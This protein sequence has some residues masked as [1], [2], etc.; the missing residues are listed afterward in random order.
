MS[1]TVQLLV[2]TAAALLLAAL[3]MAP[4]VP[5]DTDDAELGVIKAG[6]LPLESKSVSAV[7][8]A[9]TKH[10]TSEAMHRTLVVRVQFSPDRGAK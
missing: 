8:T 10:E 4:M 7:D 6:A 3:P 9:N 5:V 1:S 2:P